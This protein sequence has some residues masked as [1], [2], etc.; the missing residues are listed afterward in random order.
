M[1]LRPFED[2]ALDSNL[3]QDKKKR[4]GGAIKTQGNQECY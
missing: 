3:S 1:I 4:G 2:G